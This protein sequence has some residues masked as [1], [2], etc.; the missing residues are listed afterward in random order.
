VD[1]PLDAS[2]FIT[3]PCAVLTRE[4]LDGFSVGGLGI[5]TTSGGVAK[6][7]GPFCSWHADPELDSTMAVGFI[8]GNKNGLADMYRGRERFEDFRPVEVDGYPG[9]FA[10]SPDLRAS[11]SCDLAVGVSGTLMIRASEQ[12]QLDAHGACE[13]AVQV[14]RAALKTLRGDRVPG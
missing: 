6:Y 14:A 5:P 11:G 13:R 12:G 4:Q 8:T 2:R 10:N 7:A 3:D 1:D 9:V